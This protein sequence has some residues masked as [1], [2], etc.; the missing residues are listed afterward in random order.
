[1]SHKGYVFE[2]EIEDF[3]LEFTGQT[4]KDPILKS[5]KMGMIKLNRTFRIPTSGAM[6]SMKGDVITSIPWLPQQLK[7]ECKSRREKNKK[8][9]PILNV[10]L[11]WIEKNNQ[12]AYDDYQLPILVVKFKRIPHNRV[13][14]IMKETDFDALME[15]VKE[16]KVLG[17]GSA[18]ITITK[19]RIKLV[20]KELA[21]TADP[22]L[23]LIDSE[24]YYLIPHHVFNDM[25]KK[26][27]NV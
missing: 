12:E 24:D 1:M 21:E 10:E 19:T 9:G 8:D 23:F 5:D 14:W 17:L 13:W 11:D 16:Q 4:K 20:H 6:D 3:F 7:V 25:M 18:D 22:I 27:K 15:P 26:L 2:S